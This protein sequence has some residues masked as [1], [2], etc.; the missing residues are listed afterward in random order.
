MILFNRIN[1]W[2]NVRHGDSG[3]DLFSIRKSAIKSPVKSSFASG[4][5]NS[6]H[7]G[8]LSQS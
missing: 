4:A 1:K 6:V 3:P 5:K 8:V 7:I 2:E